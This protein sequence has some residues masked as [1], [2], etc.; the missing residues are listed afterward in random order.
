MNSATE[1]QALRGDFIVP[2]LHAAGR[3]RRLA[4]SSRELRDVTPTPNGVP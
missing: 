1:S 2:L 3:I 4:R